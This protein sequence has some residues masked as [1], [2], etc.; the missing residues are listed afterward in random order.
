M[1]IILLLFV[2]LTSCAELPQPVNPINVE[3]N[4]RLHF[5]GKG[6]GAGM[7]LSASMGAVGT[8]IGIAIDEGI[9]K[10]IAETAEKA[11]I[12]M[13]AILQETLSHHK[14]RSQASFNAVVIN[15]YGFIILPGDGEQATAQLHV[16]LQYDNQP[17]RNIRFPEDFLASADTFFAGLVKKPL[18]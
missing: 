17:S 14:N 16:A 5:S 8:A 4:S 15:R 2:L 3:N 18:A 11:T 6:A 12:S 13:E 9:A 1:K 7:M 10:K